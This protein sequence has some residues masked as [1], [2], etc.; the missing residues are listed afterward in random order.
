[1]THV[2]LHRRR[3]CG[4]RFVGDSGLGWPRTC[5]NSACVH[6]DLNDPDLMD[7]WSLLR[8]EETVALYPI[9]LDLALQAVRSQKAVDLLHPLPVAYRV[10]EDGTVGVPR[11][12]STTTSSTS[13]GWGVGRQERRLVV[14]SADAQRWD[15][16]T[17]EGD[18]V[19]LRELVS[20]D[21]LT[22]APDNA[23]IVDFVEQVC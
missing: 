3:R 16:D 12:T 4:C 11:K 8:V 22:W 2:M 18:I 19:L 10:N 15:L 9:M 7:V 23:A 21:A 14:S 6:A 5:R 1:M 20:P 13:S 17:L